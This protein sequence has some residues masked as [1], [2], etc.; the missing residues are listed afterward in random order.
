MQKESQGKIEPSGVDGVGSM[1]GARMLGF[2]LAY[3]LLCLGCDRGCFGWIGWP[4][5]GWHEYLCMQR[6]LCAF[7]SCFLLVPSCC[8]KGGF[9]FQG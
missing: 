4:I 2:G 7:F 3:A 8:V 6:G 1:L 9:V 5:V